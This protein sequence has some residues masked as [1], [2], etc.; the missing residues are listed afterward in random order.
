M[1]IRNPFGSCCQEHKDNYLMHYTYFNPYSLS[2]FF[3]YIHQQINGES[4][5]CYSTSNVR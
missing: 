5:N 3:E 4:L 1:I 2:I